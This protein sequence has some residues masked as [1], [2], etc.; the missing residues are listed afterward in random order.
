MNLIIMWPH[1]CIETDCQIKSAI[2]FYQSRL[3]LERI[4]ITDSIHVLSHV[5]FIH[6]R[7]V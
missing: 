6:V 2:F 4:T 5:D 3:Y 7:T 1:M